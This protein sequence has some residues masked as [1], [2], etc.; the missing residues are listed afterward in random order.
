[1][2]NFTEARLKAA[3]AAVK[4]AGCHIARVF[5]DPSGKIEIVTVNGDVS[6]P[7]NDLDAE[8]I[9]FQARHGQG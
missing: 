4:N 1:M 2:S 3:V 5:I 8:L 7:G 6:P 9:A